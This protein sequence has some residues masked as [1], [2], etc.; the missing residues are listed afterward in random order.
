[1]MAYPIITDFKRTSQP[2]YRYRL[3][4]IFSRKKNAPCPVFTRIIIERTIG[5]YLL[6]QKKLMET[7][8][9][10]IQFYSSVHLFVENIQDYQ[11]VTQ[12]ADGS[13]PSQRVIVPA[14]LKAIF[15]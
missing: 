11:E 9:P 12:L 15:A 4:M 14:L 7:S 2:I 10:S 1:M 5:R 13:V 3:S 6:F 8:K